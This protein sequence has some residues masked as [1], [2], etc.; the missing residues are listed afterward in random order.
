MKQEVLLACIKRENRIFLARKRVE[1]HTKEE[2]EFPGGKREPYE[3][4]MEGIKRELNEEFGLEIQA[5]VELHDFE[6]EDYKY[7]IFIAEWKAGPLWCTDH[8]I[9]GWFEPQEISAIP[10]RPNNQWMW[11]NRIAAFINR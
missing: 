11:E 10:L 4:A 8:D 6:A 1:N 3:S 5:L 9:W 7:R 2:W